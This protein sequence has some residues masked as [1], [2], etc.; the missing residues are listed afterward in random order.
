MKKEK[1]HFIGVAGSGMSALAQFHVMGGGW[2]TGSDRTFDQGGAEKLREKLEKLDIKIF[3]QDGSGVSRDHDYGVLSTA[4]EQENPDLDRAKELG[5]QIKHRSEQLEEHVLNHRTIAVAGTSGKSTVVAMIFEILQAARLSPSVITGAGLLS[6]EKKGYWGNA[7]RGKS[8]LL[9]IEADESDGTL[10]QYRPWLGVLLNISKD[11]KEVQEIKELFRAFHRNA[12][13]FVVQAGTSDLKEFEKGSVTFGFSSGKIQAENLELLPDRSRFSISKI[14]FS[15]PLPGKH[16]V[17][18]LLAAVAACSMAGVDLAPCAKALASY[19]G[20]AR[21]FQKIG[22]AQG[23]DVVDDYAHNP[24]KLEAALATA[25]LKAKRVHAIFQL[26]GYAPSRFL[27]EDIVRAFS[28]FLRPQDVL[29]MP[30]IYYAGGTVTKNIS[31]RDFAE[32][33][34]A[35]GRQAHFFAQRSQLIPALIQTVQPGDLILVMGARDPS[36]S[37]FAQEILST[38]KKTSRVS[39]SS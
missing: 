16:N 19:Q 37:D 9:V 35:G 7:F 10:T 28:S 2:A 18:N 26:H 34:K 1:V 6:L 13:S 32:A 39:Q 21:R 29:W 14:P 30:E 31:A 11:H 17:E 33:L 24:A 12:R 23:V 15:L 8:D 3:P 25:Q 4:I 5:V 36:L 20:V 27:K 38:L 22:T